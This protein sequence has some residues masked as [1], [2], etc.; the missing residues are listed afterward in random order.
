[1]LDRRD[2]SPRAL[3]GPASKAIVTAVILLVAAVANGHSFAE[4]KSPSASLPPWKQGGIPVNP[5]MVRTFD[6]SSCALAAGGI[7]CP[8]IGPSAIFVLTPEEFQALQNAKHPSQTE[9][10]ETKKALVQ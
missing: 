10:D 3:A 4:D 8:V 5:D 7:V 6:T 1:M 9:L 2:R